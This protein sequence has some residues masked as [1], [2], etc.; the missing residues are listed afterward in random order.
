[1]SRDSYIC[2]G[3]Y[4]HMS[5][6]S[7]FQ[8]DT[9]Y[10]PLAH[11]LRPRRVEDL[12]AIKNQTLFNWLNNPNRQSALLWGP[13]GTGK[14]TIAEMAAELSHKE[15]IKMHAF[16]SGVKDLRQVI[17][18]ARKLPNTIILFVDEVHNFNKSQQDILLD[19]LET[20]ILTFI[21]ATTE[22]PAVSINKALSSRM[23]KFEL[24]AHR[25]EDHA[26]LV[27]RACKE[28]KLTIDRE[29]MDFLIK[30]S[31][32]DARILLT[33][34]ESA[35]GAAVD[36]E[37]SL[38]AVKSITDGKQYSGDAN[39]YYDCVSALQKS[40]RGSDPDAA[41]YWLARLLHSGGE[42]KSIARRILVT[43]S[44]DVGLADPMALVVAQA[45][46]DA[47]L[48]LGMPE[49]RI[50]LAQAVAY[51]ARAPKSNESYMALNRALHDCKNHPP[52][53][54]PGH[55]API[56]G[57]CPATALNQKGEN[58]ITKYKYPHDY[59]GNWVEQQYLPDELKGK[60]YLQD[61]TSNKHHNADDGNTEE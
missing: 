57:F 3:Y 23:I 60:Q 42:L 56:K 19:A 39:T 34:F 18:Q 12:V 47:A 54:V 16:D 15:F 17:E 25:Y 35:A 50:P 52:Y 26:V 44:E 30:A 43:A 7:L 49:A 20:G 8:S 24:K 1:M 59:P 21:G 6:S 38:E 32:G 10:Q 37:I 13:P 46:Y 45:A 29:A 22:N 2:L 61:R 27:D 40:L 48:T 58:P 33:N 51:I 5:Q 41:I 11:R 14:T 55:L 4:I 31:Y 36:T 53:E 9:S 28:L